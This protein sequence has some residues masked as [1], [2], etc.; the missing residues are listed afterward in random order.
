MTNVLLLSELEKG[1]PGI[2]QKVGSF[3]AEASSHC[4]HLNHHFSGVCLL[5]EGDS[6][7]SFEV[8]WDMENTHQIEA[9]WSDHQEATEYGACG[10]A[11]LLVLRLTQYTVIQRSRKGTKF[12]YWLGHRD[13]EHPFERSARLEVSGILVGD[14]SNF[15]Q[16]VKEKRLQ[17]SESESSL[18][19]YVVV[20][21]F[22]KP[23]SE[24][25]ALENTI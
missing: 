2:T 23:K 12:D 6:P 16:R 10:V 1:L 17:I 25:T 20:V 3:L 8:Q 4:F 22:G 21:E 13:G 24:L 15:R 9:A 11:I 7:S 19:A 5:V 14:D 18:P